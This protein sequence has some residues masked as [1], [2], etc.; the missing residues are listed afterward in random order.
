M[1]VPLLHFEEFYI[2]DERC[3]RGNCAWRAALA[4]AKA[5]RNNEASLASDTHPLDSFIPTLDHLT[6]A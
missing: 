1:Q 6:A 5:W 4:I 2:K 3:I